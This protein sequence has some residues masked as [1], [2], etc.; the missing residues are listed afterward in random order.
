MRELLKTAQ[1]KLDDA[2]KGVEDVCSIRY[3]MGYAQA[4]RDVN[5][6]LRLEGLEEL[7]AGD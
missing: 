5:K 1:Q 7:E 3:Y 2:C 4:I 6:K